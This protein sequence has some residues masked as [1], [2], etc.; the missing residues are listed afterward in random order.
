MCPPPADIG[1]YW[2]DEELI[3]SL[4]GMIRG[5]PLPG[6]VLEEIN[7]YFHVPENLPNDI[8]YFICSEE[9]KDRESGFWKVKGEACQVFTNSAI[10]GWRT[11]LEF[12]EGQAPHGSKTNWLMQ[13]Y[14]ITHKGPCENC[15]I[16]ESGSLCR[17]FLLGGQS[18]NS[19]KNNQRS[20]HEKYSA[21]GSSRNPVQ[22]FVSDAKRISGQGF[23]HN[24][25][26]NLE[27]YDFGPLVVSERQQNIPVVN[28]PE[29]NYLSDGDY[30]E[31]RD[32]ESPSF[33]SDNSSCLTMS[34]EECFDSLALLQDLS[35]ESNLDSQQKDAGCKFSISSSHR[36]NEVVLCPATSGSLH[37]G[38]TSK[39]P[40][41]ETARIECSLP[42]SPMKQKFHGKMVP[43]PQIKTQKADHRSKS[44]SSGSHTRAAAGGKKEGGVSRTK[45]IKKKYLCFMPF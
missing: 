3:T 20:N 45:E 41:N 32:L 5:S 34:S 33:S 39:L 2:T 26:V 38:E 42:G 17:V 13:E 19:E 6:N 35:Y 1:V 29:S 31:L 40:T 16:K 30:L 8:W 18:K 14:R 43:V 37:S 9:K 24:S 25:Q 28:L 4:E 15:R 36:P 44:P 7:P 22:P 10:I 12:Y 11:T 21:D 27:G 23:D